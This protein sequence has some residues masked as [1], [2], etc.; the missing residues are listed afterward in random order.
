VRSGP[1]AG[2]PT[3]PDRLRWGEQQRAGSPA[4]LMTKE[5]L[6]VFISARGEAQ[7]HG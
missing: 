7:A 1:R 3:R 4:K 6:V 5:N 2:R